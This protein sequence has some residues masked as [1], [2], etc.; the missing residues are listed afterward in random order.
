MRKLTLA[1]A[2]LA[3]PMWLLVQGGCKPKVKVVKTALDVTGAVASLERVTTEPVN[4]VRPAI[5]PDG[6]ILLF[7]VI[8][9]ERG[10][11]KKTIVGVDPSTRAQRTLYTSDKSR[12]AD[13]VWMPDQSSYIYASDAP[14]SWSLVRALT[15]TPNAAVNVV[16]AG[17]IANSPGW[18]TVSPDGK[19]IAFSTLAHNERNIAIIGIDG[20]R[21]TL[22]GA[23]DSPAWS[24]D[25]K[26]I[27]FG[28]NVGRHHH[29]FL[30]DPESGTNLVQL[31]SGDFDH[32]DPAWSPDGQYIIFSTN[33]AS[34]VAD[35]SATPTK[36]AAP[37]GFNLYIVNRDGTGLTQ[38]TSGDA[39]AV[40]PNWGSDGWIYFA[41][42][43]S[44][45][46]DIWRLRPVGKYA[47]LKSAA[48]APT[49]APPPPPPP[50]P[51][52]SSAAAPPAPTHP[53][54]A[55][56]P[57]GGGCTKDTDCKGDRVCD[58]G[59]CVS[60]SAPPAPPPPAPPGKH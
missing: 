22:I 1:A 47:D 30:I 57:S 16:A 41:S 31:T 32:N 51:P 28:R 2:A 42:D 17:E 53:G 21:L 44:G 13:P 15:S 6:K 8:L 36:A 11:S 5:S 59:S 58:H 3:L 43:Q 37:R 46:F 39:Q 24:P 20:A 38:V 12:S 23:G 56:P 60:P 10:V 54:P 50:P 34:D 55:A 14:G 29:L 45:D 25:G 19:R 52:S 7:N 40:M 26:R 35:T 33:R 48:A 18:P 9:V 27:V 49:E 4:E